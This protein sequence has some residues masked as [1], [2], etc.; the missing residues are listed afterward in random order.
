MSEMRR[1]LVLT[2]LLAPCLPAAV[3][4]TIASNPSGR[5]F[6]VS[7]TDCSAGPHSTPQILDWPADGSCTV[8][9]DSRPGTRYRFAGW[10]DGAANNSRTIDT[11]RQAT[12]Y[13]ANFDSASAGAAIPAVQLAPGDYG[14]TQIATMGSAS[15]INNS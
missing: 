13:T 11:P 2:L 7:G 15:A 8:T 6:T 14:A 1:L 12:T 9:F 10:H 5:I 3:E 4:I